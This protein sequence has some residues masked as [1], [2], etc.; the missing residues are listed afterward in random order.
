MKPAKKTRYVFWTSG[1]D[2]T[3]MVIRLLRDGFVVQPLYIINPKRKSRYY[4]LAALDRLSELISQRI[5]TGK[6][7][8]YKTFELAEIEPDTEVNQAFEQ[9]NQGL[10]EG[11]R[12]LGYQYRYL[13]S[14]AK[15]HP[16]FPTIGVGIEKLPDL[17]HGLYSLIHRLGKLTPDNQIDESSAPELLKLLGKFDF[18][19]INITEREMVDNIKAWGYKD[20]MEQIWFCHKPIRGKV[21]GACNPCTDKIASKME[22]L[23]PQ[24]ALCRHD[25]LAQTKQRYGKLAEHIQSGFYRLRGY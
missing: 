21:C 22:F 6:L 1:W 15:Q 25:K 18:P 11:Q 5:P 3:Y 4:E 13:A 10:T 23:L 9:I 8:P 12:P 7:L 17:N 24:A 16:E 20:I 14:F 19:I 2:S